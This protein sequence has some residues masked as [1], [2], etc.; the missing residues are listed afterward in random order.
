MTPL[1]SYTVSEV[2]ALKHVSGNAIRDAIHLGRIVARRIDGVY[3]IDPASAEAWQPKRQTDNRNSVR[4]QMLDC[5]NMPKVAISTTQAAR[6]KGVSPRTVKLALLNGR[7]CGAKI[8]WDGNT[9]GYVY[10]I[11]PA[12]LDAW[13]PD[14]QWDGEVVTH[15]NDDWATAARER[16]AER[17]YGEFWLK[18]GGR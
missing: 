18:W 15:L 14:P 3:Y 17:D 2:A 10:D 13:Q 8:P 1:D 5:S 9:A 12:S 4:E 7:L 16:E 6:L 11:D